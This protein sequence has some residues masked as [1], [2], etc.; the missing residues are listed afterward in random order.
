[1]VTPLPVVNLGNDTIACGSLLLDAGNPGDTYLWSDNSTSQTLTVTSSNDYYVTVTHLTCSSTD[2]IN[3]G[4]N[5]PPV[6]FLSLPYDTVCR[7][8]GSQTLSGG[9]PSGGSFSG[10][11]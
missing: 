4:I 2:T 5:L 11:G 10:T 9:A 3:V 1:A 6:V 8:G 7:F